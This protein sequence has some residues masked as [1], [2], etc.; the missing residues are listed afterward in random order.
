MRRV[1]LGLCMTLACAG[2]LFAIGPFMLGVR[3]GLPLENMVN[4]TANTLGY[5]ANTY[6][7]TVGPTVGIN[8]PHRVSV[9]ADALYSGST[10]RGPRR[11]PADR[12]NPRELIP[13]RSRSC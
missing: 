8:L 6:D 11:L 7:F 5:S 1:T 9:E 2:N 3:G 10:S 13:G 4:G 12:S